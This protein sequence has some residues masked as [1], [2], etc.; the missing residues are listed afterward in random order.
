MGMAK[1]WF[2]RVVQ[3]LQIPEDIA[4]HLPLVHLTGSCRARVENHRGIAEYTP[5]LIRIDSAAGL[6][7]IR[8]RELMVKELARDDL[9]CVGKILAVEFYDQPGSGR[10]GG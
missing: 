10:Q 9:I 7:V 4:L 5:E 6:V 8:G 2:T 1:R 3:R